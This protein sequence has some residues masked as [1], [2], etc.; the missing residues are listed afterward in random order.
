MIKESVKSDYAT[1]LKMYLA[2]PSSVMPLY[3][4]YN[5]DKSDYKFSDYTRELEDLLENLQTGKF[6]KHE[7]LCKE[8]LRLKLPHNQ[9]DCSQQG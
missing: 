9:F 3:E 4:Q 7:D 5:Q 6:K 2:N 8:I 1:K